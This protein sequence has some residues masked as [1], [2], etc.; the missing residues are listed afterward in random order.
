MVIFTFVNYSYYSSFFLLDCFFPYLTVKAVC[1][2]LVFSAFL[3]V[4][5]FSFS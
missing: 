3:M 5:F 1:V 2:L 4:L